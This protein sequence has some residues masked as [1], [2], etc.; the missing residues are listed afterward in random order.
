MTRG[1]GYICCVC[2]HR[3]HACERACVTERVVKHSLIYGR[4]IFKFALNILQITT[5]SIGYVLFMSTHRARACVRAR[6]CGRALGKNIH[7]SLDGFSS[8]VLCI[9]YRWLQATLATHLS[10]RTAGTRESARVRAREWLT[11]RL[12]MDGFSS[13]LG[14]TY[15][16]SQQVARDTYFSCS[17]TARTCASARMRARVYER[18]R[19]LTVN[20]LDGFSSNLMGTYYKWPQVTWDTYWSCVI[21]ACMRACASVR[22]RACVCERE[23]D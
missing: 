18:A 23:C 19:G 20:Y 1:V 2:T 5:S 4:T 7:S 6:A 8:N 11:V 22:V 21:T 12:F 14:W 10:L 15:Y 3:V 13:N 16:T 9:Y 17:R